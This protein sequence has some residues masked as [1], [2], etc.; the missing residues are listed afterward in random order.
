M[1]KKILMVTITTV[2]A[3]STFFCGVTYSNF[4][5]NSIP[6]SDIATMIVNDDGYY[7]LTIKDIHNINDNKS[8]ISYDDIMKL[9]NR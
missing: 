1:K 4:N 2:I 6:T 8:N 9:V 3:V 7:Q 5:N